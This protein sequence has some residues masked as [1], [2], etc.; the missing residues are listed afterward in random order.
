MSERIFI[1]LMTHAC[2]QNGVE[3]EVLSNGWLLRMNKNDR[4]RYVIGSSFDLNPQASAAIA[5]DKAATSTALEREA[6]AH[7]RHIVLRSADMKRLPVIILQEMFYSG[8]VVIKPLEGERGNYVKRVHTAQQVE[9]TLRHHSVVTWAASPFMDIAQEYRIVMIG[10]KV[11]LAYV[12]T[13]PVVLDGLKFFNLSK[14]AT[15]KP[16]AVSDIP[17]DVCD[18]A[19]SAMAALG[20]QVAAVDIVQDSGGKVSILEVNASFS[21]VRYAQTNPATYKDVAG[22]YERLVETM[23]ATS[24]GDVLVRTPYAS[25]NVSRSG[26]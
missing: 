7:I 14:G 3:L 17:N 20:L 21:L 26:A 6:I 10:D 15:A 18:L 11:E 9:S 12:K 24:P 4:V 2:G 22:F 1:D 19:S 13:N 5:R 25:T 16:V 23:F 8:D